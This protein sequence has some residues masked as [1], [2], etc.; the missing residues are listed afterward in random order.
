MQIISGLLC[1]AVSFLLFC[2]A[3]V[4]GMLSGDDITLIEKLLYVGVFVLSLIGSAVGIGLY[5]I[6][7]EI[8][9]S[10]VKHKDLKEKELELMKKQIKQHYNANELKDKEL[11]LIS[12]ANYL[13]EKEITFIEQRLAE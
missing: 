7:D 12:K 2:V 6:C 8:K 1:F 5:D 11:A 13:K 9:T 4:T 10:S 3:L